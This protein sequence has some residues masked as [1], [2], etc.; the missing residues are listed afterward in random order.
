MANAEPIA[1]HKT[2]NGCFKE[3]T[4][5]YVWNALNPLDMQYKENKI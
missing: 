4:L 1:D 5:G 2:F 3:Y